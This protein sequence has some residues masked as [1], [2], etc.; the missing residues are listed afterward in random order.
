MKMIQI[1]NVPDALH[2]SLKARAAREGRSLSDLILSD[3]P[4]LA[5][6]PAPE[7]LMS[8]IESRSSVGGPP[9]SRADRRG[10]RPAL[11]LVV[12]A[13]AVTEL[14]LGRDAGVRVA[15]H[16]AGHDFALHAP[17]L[18]DVEVLSALRR[19]VSSG[20]AT[21]ERAGEAITDLL[22][23]PIERYPHDVLVPRIWQLRE[24][25]SAYDAG[26]VA[27]AEAV[28][29]EPVPLLTAD[30]RLAHAITEHCDVPVLLAS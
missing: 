16:F 12:D 28:A 18:V 15:E 20:E 1:R 11:M 8:R 25:F 29:D 9:A 23:L 4:R 3:L 14:L 7:D 24:N 30:A 13:S 5:D 27:L 2:R 21:S 19:L 17:H 10:A 6:K 22:D 26:Y